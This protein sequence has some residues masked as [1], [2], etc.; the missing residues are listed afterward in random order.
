MNPTQLARL[1]SDE[2]YCMTLEVQAKVI[3]ADAEAFLRSRPEFQVSQTVLDVG[4]G[5]GSLVSELSGLFEQKKY[6]G[7]DVKESFIRRAKERTRGFKNVQFD[8]ADLYQLDRGKYDVI[9]L[10]AVLQHLQDVPAAFAVLSQRLNDRGTFIVMDTNSA[11][12]DFQATP[13]IPGLSKMYSE[14]QLSSSKRGRNIDCLA[15]TKN[16]AARNGF[17]INAERITQAI[18]T[19]AEDKS[20]YVSYTLFVS[21]LLDRFYQIKTDQQLLLKELESW[22]ATPS[23]SV[24]L[25]GGTWI[26]FSRVE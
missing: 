15:Q 16:W 21:E 23:S 24:K 11:G 25:P 6:Y 10:F 22:E 8:V 17:Q 3:R 26:S 4:C 7:I 13:E 18:L 5:P 9:I 1:D 20:T 19:S 14:L 2:L 12:D